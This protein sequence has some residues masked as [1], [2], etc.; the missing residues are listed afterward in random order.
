MRKQ[1]NS[2]WTERLVGQLKKLWGKGYSCSQIAVEIGNGITRNAVIGKAH[3]LGLSERESGFRNVNLHKRLINPAPPGTPR[4]SKPRTKPTVFKSREI[5][6]RAVLPRTDLGFQLVY[7]N[8][9][10][11]P[12]HKIANK[13]RQPEM[14][15]DQLRAMLSQAMQNTAAMEGQA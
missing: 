14:T 13:Y 9:T 11:N 1:V 10:G 6:P 7:S 2:P 12:L 3:R 15:K 8:I 4:A 5:K